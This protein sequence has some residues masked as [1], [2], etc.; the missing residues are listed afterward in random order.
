MKIR[1]VAAVV[2]LAIATAALAGGTREFD[3]PSVART[4]K[5]GF[6][7]SC[8]ARLQDVETRLNGV[9]AVTTNV[10]AQYTALSPGSIADANTKA[11]AQ[12]DRAADKD[13]ARA[14]DDLLKACQELRR[15]VNDL[16]KEVRSLTTAREEAP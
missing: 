13:L 4:A 5:S 16:R 6:G 7:A 8:K 14:V 10:V 3:N 9:E 1:V 15:S 2:L 12:G 11:F